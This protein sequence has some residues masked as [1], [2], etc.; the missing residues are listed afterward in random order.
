MRKYPT[1]SGFP[2]AIED[3][4]RLAAKVVG[5]G[6][7]RK[8]ILGSMV[9]FQQDTLDIVRIATA[10]LHHV[11]RPDQV[12]DQDLAFIREGLQDI[13]TLGADNAQRVA[14]HQLQEALKL[15]G[16]DGAYSLMGLETDQPDLDV[17]DHNLFQEAHVDAIKKFRTFSSTVKQQSVDK[18]KQNKRGGGGRRGGGRYS[19]FQSQGQYGGGY[20]RGGQRGGFNSSSRGGRGGGRGGRQFHSGNG[21]GGSEQKDD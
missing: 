15:A 3:D 17:S 7:N 8:L 1:F 18:Y 12:S 4:N 20:R 14:K 10:L 16:A 11:A 19:T 21:Q 2:R 13:V 9:K 6:A 5:D